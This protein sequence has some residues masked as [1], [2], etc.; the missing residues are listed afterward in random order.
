LKLRDLTLR[1][2]QHQVFQAYQEIVVRKRKGTQ[3]T[4]AAL[5][6]KLYRKREKIFPNPKAR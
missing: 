5:P 6:H 3:Y 1:S 2:N 4:S